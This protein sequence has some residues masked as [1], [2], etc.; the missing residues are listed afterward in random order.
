VE[1]VHLL[2]RPDGSRERLGL[3]EATRGRPRVTAADTPRAGVYRIQPE[4]N[5]PERPAGA[6]FAVTPDLRESED[7]TALSDKDLDDLLGYQAVHVTAG[8]EAA[9]TALSLRSGRGGHW[10]CWRAS[11]H[12]AVEAVFAWFCSRAW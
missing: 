1:A 9:D 2:V 12:W 5:N 10:R 7:L 8:E 6:V 11:R 3:P 4:G